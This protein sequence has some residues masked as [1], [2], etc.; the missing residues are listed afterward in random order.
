[1]DTIKIKRKLKS[2]LLKVKEL[3][4]FKGKKIELEIKVKEIITS[5]DKKKNKSFAGVFANFANGN[6]IES[7]N[8]AWSLA[9]SDKHE[10]YRR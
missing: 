6:L 7:E 8:S 4:K 3:E 5:E 2:T 9:V 10:N 1:M